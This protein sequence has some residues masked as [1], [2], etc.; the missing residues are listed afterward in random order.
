MDRGLE[1]ISDMSNP[2]S[3]A[4]DLPGGPRHIVEVSGRRSSEDLISK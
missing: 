4:D 2:T 1:G 3:R